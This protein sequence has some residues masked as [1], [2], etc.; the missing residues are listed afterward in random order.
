MASHLPQQ[1][2][3]MG[4]QLMVGGTSVLLIALVFLLA[5]RYLLFTQAGST[6]PSSFIE[7][8][9]TRNRLART[10]AT[11]DIFAGVVSVAGLGLVVC[12]LVLFLRSRRVHQPPRSE[13]TVPAGEEAHH[14]S[15]GFSHPKQVPNG[16]EKRRL[17]PWFV[18]LLLVGVVL[19][20]GP[21]GPAASGF[22]VR[23]ESE[24][25]V[26][27]PGRRG[28][29]LSQPGTVNLL[30]TLIGEGYTDLLPYWL[31]VTGQWRQ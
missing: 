28:A 27:L 29:V 16:R 25:L 3:R 6:R 11:V 30:A 7:E 5:A 9:E 20:A 2:K 19:P 22:S 13:A 4:P 1:P 15:S 12:G 31:E 10:L 23:T 17:K 26:I 18:G 24:V 14:E 8:L 21:F